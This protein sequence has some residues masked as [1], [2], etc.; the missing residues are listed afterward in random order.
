MKV[1]DLIKF[2]IAGLFFIFLIA[3]VLCII[4]IILVLKSNLL[5][6]IV[7][8]GFNTTMFIMT[9]SNLLDRIK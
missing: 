9:I 4:P 3:Y 8:I 5:L 1:I 7:F 2:I 6:L